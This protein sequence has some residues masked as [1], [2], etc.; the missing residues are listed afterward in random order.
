MLQDIRDNA[1]SWAAKTIVGL[2]VVSFAIWGIHSIIGT[3]SSQPAVA[4]VNGEDITQQKFQE[5]VE[6]QK[7]QE[8][9]QMQ[10]P[11]PASIDMAKL[12]K[13]VLNGLIEQT[14]LY[15][16]AQE[17]G[18]GL[19]KKDLDSIISSLPQFQ[20][21][22]KFSEQAFMN[23][24][25]NLGMTV[26][27][28]RDLVR[29]QYLINQIRTGV[30]A[31]SFTTPSAVQDLLR[32]QKQ[33]RSFA[34]LHLPASLVSDQV[35]VSDSD[36]KAYY[37]KH[38]ST[39]VKPE[40]VDA[41]YIELSASQLMDQVQVSDSEMQNLYK[42]KMADYQAH[43][44]REAAHIL[45]QD[46]GPEK[47]V[48][49]KLQMI[50][51]K[52]DDGESFA[53]L[54]KEYSDDVASAKQGGDLGYAPKGTYAPAFDKALFSMKKGQVKGPIKTQYGYHFIKLLAVRKEPKP[55]FEAMKGKLHDEIAKKK[56]DQLF[57]KKLATLKDKA[58]TAYDLQEPAKDLGLKVQVVKGVT[59]QGG[60][61]PFGHPGLDKALFSDD[62]LNNGNNTD[63]IHL[64]D[65][66]VVVARVRK[67]YP[68]SEKPLDEVQDQIRDQLRSEQAIALLN[69]K[70]Q[71]LMTKV[72]GGEGL[73]AMAG[74]VGQKW[75]DH[76]AVTRNANGIDAPVLEKAFSMPR[77]GK[78]GPSLATLDQGKGVDLIALKKVTE[79]DLSDMKSQEKQ[80]RRFLAQQQ[81][82]R[83]YLDYTDQVKNE[84]KVE[85]Y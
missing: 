30:M 4:K 16:D 59:R 33:K 69:K 5:T 55:T 9:S 76:S 72:Q 22:G 21:D 36:L 65:N 48:K 26:G 66:N 20:Q 41:A 10:N 24:V 29:Q 23:A 78:S 60:P 53:K 85:R 57:A 74:S 1:Q 7:Q 37:E 6:L 47:K 45:I 38:K 49:A 50:Q 17:Q 64:G 56:A 82:R 44:E 77:P 18:L 61:A 67:H 19:T 27:G 63:V 2:L 70:A 46:K 51:K 13:S 42:Q 75:Q 71:S 52:L 35:K 80:Y 68:K 8:L 62:V 79:P 12:K 28:F 15:Q 32:L 83:E 39:F 25:R 81:G 3:F 34:V 11:D 58:F 43:E 14:A 84:A 31:S 40:S 54:A 73:D